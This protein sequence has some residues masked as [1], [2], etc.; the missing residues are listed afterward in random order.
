MGSVKVNGTSGVNGV[1]GDRHSMVEGA[2]AT[3]KGKRQYYPISSVYIVDLNPSREQY[4]YENIPFRREEDYEK[5]LARLA[6]AKDDNERKRIGLETGILRLP[7]LVASYAHIYPYFFSL[8]AVHQL[9]ANIAS[10][11]HRLMIEDNYLPPHKLE[12]FGFWLE[13]AKAT[14]PSTF[15]GPVRNIYTKLNT[16]FKLYEWMAVVHWYTVPFLLS[17]G[18]RYEVVSNYALFVRIAEFSMRME[19]RTEEDLQKFEQLIIEFLTGFEKLYITDPSKISRARLTLFQLIHIPNHIRWYGSF[20]LCSQATCERTIGYLG[21]KVRSDKSPFQH[22]A[23]IIMEQEVIKCLKLYYPD[24]VPQDPPK[25]TRLLHKEYQITRAE[26]AAPFSTWNQHRNAIYQFKGWDIEAPGSDIPLPT[27][28]GKFS[29]DSG[30]TLRSEMS[31]R[32]GKSSRSSRYFEAVTSAGISIFGEALAFYTWDKEDKDSILVAFH[33]INGVQNVLRCTHRGNLTS[34]V[35]VI[36]AKFIRSLVGVW[37]FQDYTYV[38]R[39]HAGLAV[40]SETELAAEAEREGNA[41]IVFETNITQ[42]SE[43]MQL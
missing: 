42:T 25:P 3:D 11:L 40:L 17:L 37:A 30:V 26:R 24:L 36:E 7:L 21:R 12:K 41:G 6:N 34:E 39:K 33:R 9:Y 8:D 43:A 31:E 10:H 32:N 13:M 4:S 27:R 29:L 18:V 22:L 20:R 15:C 19:E 5:I 14:L 28:W 38:L 23:N 1:H 16:S 2:R 35:T